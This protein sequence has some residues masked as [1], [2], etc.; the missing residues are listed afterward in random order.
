MGMVAGI[1]PEGEDTFDALQGIS[2]QS[3]ARER[4]KEWHASHVG[5][6]SG[7]GG[8]AGGGGGG[9]GGGGVAIHV[10]GCPQ[11]HVPGYGACGRRVSVGGAGGG[12]QALMLQNI[13][14]TLMQLQSSMH[15]MSANIKRLADRLD[16]ADGAGAAR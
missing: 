9:G 11:V 6:G 14:S 15:E 16:T 3:L 7:G 5:D 13:G 2:F 10:P 4:Y 8:G 1:A 12:P